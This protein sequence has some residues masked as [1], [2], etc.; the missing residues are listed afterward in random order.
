[1]PGSCRKTVFWLFRES[2]MSIGRPWAM[3]PG[4]AGPQAYVEN[5]FYPTPPECVVALQPYIEDFPNFIW[6]PACG[7]GAI[8]KVLRAQGRRVL[9]TDLVNRGYGS[10]PLDFTLTKAAPNLPRALVT[11]PPYCKDLPERFI[12]H[13]FDLGVTHMALLLKADFWSARR[14]GLFEQ[15][16]PSRIHPLAWRPDFK[17][18]GSPFLN[19]AWSVWRPGDSSAQTVRLHK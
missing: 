1:M 14:G 7:D 8:A 5:G 13:A 3:V 2:G 17:G 15:F 6:E 4:A 9:A 16:T 12:R 18:Q 19:V 11:N 10:T